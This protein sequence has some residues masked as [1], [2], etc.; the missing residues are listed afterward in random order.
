MNCAVI[1]DDSEVNL[2]CASC[3]KT[4]CILKICTSCR[5]V[6]YCGIACQKAHWK[7]HKSN[8]KRSVADVAVGCVSNGKNKVV[9]GK[10]NDE[11]DQLYNRLMKE[12]ERVRREEEEEEM[13]KFPGPRDDC[14]ICFLTMPISCKDITYLPCCGKQVC[15]GC[16][17]EH[18]QRSVACPFCRT[19]LENKRDDICKTIQMIERRVSTGDPSSICYMG[20]VWK[21]AIYG[22]PRDYEKAF[23]MFKRAADLG[24]VKAHQELGNLYYFG[25]GISKD[26]S[27]AKHHW[28]VAA[29]GGDCLA[30]HNLGVNE[31][32]MGRA[33]RHYIIAARSGMKESMQGVT[34]AYREGIISKQ[35]FED[36]LRAHLESL[37]DMTSVQRD[38]ATEFGAII[39]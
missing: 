13:F 31:S 26:V 33:V 36:T 38:N 29:I 37:K 9:A 24:S 19:K 28:E 4:G 25:Q 3:G 35:H 32:D 30:R 7:T 39:Y 34:K 20:F 18:A 2:R 14:P 6:K 10:V 1:E 27:K 5:A 11:K 12:M 22:L 21:N 17:L 23:E 15:G 8:C 16:I